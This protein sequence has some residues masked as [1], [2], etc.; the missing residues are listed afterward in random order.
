[1]SDFE[2]SLVAIIGVGIVATFIVMLVNRP[3]EKSRETF[4]KRDW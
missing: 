4:D 2:A 1:M 3:V